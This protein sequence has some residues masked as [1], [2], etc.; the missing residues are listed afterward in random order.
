MDSI[1]LKAILALFFLAAGI[2]AVLFMFA[3]MGKA[4]RRM[5]ATFLRRAHKTAGAIFTILL[6]VISIFCIK[7]VGIVG[8]NI[9][10]R[11]V[12]HAVFAIALIGV[13]AVKI[14]I[15]QFYKELIRFAP[16]LGITVFVLAL[17][18]FSTSAGFY[19]VRLGTRPGVEEVT[20]LSE[21]ERI[22]E[23]IGPGDKGK[24]Q[25]G[26]AEAGKE[27]FINKCSFCHYSDRDE[28]KIGPGLKSLLKNETLPY[29]KRPATVEN[30]V[31]QMREPV[32][33]MPSFSSLSD[34]EMA[35]L[36]AFLEK[37]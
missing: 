10:T 6:I 26:D 37:L 14:V 7:R 24:V 5:S 16:A 20:T 29:S 1:L 17:V 35:N 15:V 8:D 13:L 2:A 4:E 23:E 25:V 36:I 30:V 22:G 21:R 28:A 19:F 33:T 18:V 9:S 11:S 32:G 34:E 31:S 3:L 27:I 12:F